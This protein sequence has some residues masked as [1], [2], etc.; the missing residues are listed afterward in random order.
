MS[1]AEQATFCCTYSKCKNKISSVC[2]KFA[3]VHISLCC[4][5]E[6]KIHVTTCQGQVWDL[7]KRLNILNILTFLSCM[8]IC[9]CFHLLNNAEILSQV[10]F[11]PLWW[12][13]LAL[14]F[15]YTSWERIFTF[16]KGWCFCFQMP[17]KK[18]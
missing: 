17:T 4:L 14:G 15:S 16:G 10:F 5:L 3:T 1:S 6:I 7:S 13:I 18:L 11:F 8:L 12:P 2:C 9:A